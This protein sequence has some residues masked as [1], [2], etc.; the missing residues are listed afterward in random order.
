MRS[1]APRHAL[2]EWRA[3][4]V[5][6]RLIVEGELLL[7]GA[8]RGVPHNRRLV[9]RPREQVLACGSETRARARVVGG[10]RRVRRR[11]CGRRAPVRFH[12]IEK[13]GPL[14]FVS[15]RSSLPAAPDQMRAC[16]SY[17]PV[18]RLAPSGLQS[19]VVTSFTFSLS[20]PTCC[21]TDGAAIALVCALPHAP[22]GTAQIRA[23][24][25]PDPDASWSDVGL[26]AQMNTSPSWPARVVTC[27]SGVSSPPPPSVSIAT[28]SELDAPPDAPLPPRFSAA[29][30]CSSENGSVDGWSVPSA[31]I[32][33]SSSAYM[34][35]FW[36]KLTSWPGGIL[37]PLMFD[38]ATIASH[39][40]VNA[41]WRKPARSGGRSSACVVCGGLWC[42][43]VHPRAVHRA[44][45][46]GAHRS[47][48]DIGT[49]KNSPRL[50]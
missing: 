24:E 32:E 29:G 39:P 45:G 8:R 30:D 40:K 38:F 9:E 6:R 31:A 44:G 22:L 42:A 26:H 2:A 43:V 34:M 25:S 49:P 11:V 1:V 41:E 37:A 5:E 10:R 47:R 21:S 36:M 17:A 35:P 4:N 28:G 13:I 14:C 48:A 12:L 27:S 16:P 23:V 18:A 46:G 7:D 50:R 19:S 15:V 33:R 3:A 20:A